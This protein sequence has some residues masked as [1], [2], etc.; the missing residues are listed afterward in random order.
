M[1]MLINPMALVRA[2]L[3]A[4][5]LAVIG[6]G[7]GAIFVAIAAAGAFIYN[8]WSGIQAMF[9]GIGQG[10]RAAFPGAGPI[11]DAIS[12]ALSTLFGWFTSITGTLDYTEEQWRAFGESIGTAI[13]D[14]INAA[15][16]WGRNF[17]RWLGALPGRAW[18]AIS[19][20]AASLY[21]AG[22]ALLQRLWDGAQTKFAEAV[23][24]AGTLPWRL[25]EALAS[26]AGALLAAG[27]AIIQSLWDG[28]QAKF[29]EVLAW[30]AALPG[31]I[32]AAVGNIDLSGVV[33]MPAI[34]GGAAA[35][36]PGVARAAGA[37]GAMAGGVGGAP[38]AGAPPARAS[39]APTAGAPPARAAGGPVTAGQPYIVGERRPELFVPGQSGRIEPRVPAGGGGTTNIAPSFTFN[40]TGGGDARAIA[41]EAARMMESRLRDL[42]RGLQADTGFAT[43]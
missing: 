10:I 9:V 4:I 18:T 21:A 15:I 8:N 32:V 37:A 2:G 5:R 20:G 14:G 36:P 12:S 40:I 38:T 17:L 31:R 23:A 24:W 27:G 25:G 19:S 6:T 11:I 13:G 35:P 39:G 28:A 34:L 1:L 41:D 22:I 43:P 26:A 33:R 3:F 30:F 29:G 7:I 16:E 42:L